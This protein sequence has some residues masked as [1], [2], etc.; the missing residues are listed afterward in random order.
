MITDTQASQALS[1]T[2]VARGARAPAQR[3]KEKWGG[4]IY[5]GKL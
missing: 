1:Y 2:G 5:G 4:I 3:E